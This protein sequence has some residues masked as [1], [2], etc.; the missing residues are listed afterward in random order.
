MNLR[1]ALFLLTHAVATITFAAEPPHRTTVTSSADKP[2]PISFTVSPTRFDTDGR[3]HAPTIKTAPAD[4]TYSV[5]GTTRA[6]EPGHY[7]FIATASGKYVGSITCNWEIRSP[8]N[9]S[10]SIEH[11]VYP[12]RRDKSPDIDPAKQRKSKSERQP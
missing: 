4:A 5:T 12:P 7:T 9:D 3:E 6:K 11:K 8:K 1:T 10:G 2:I